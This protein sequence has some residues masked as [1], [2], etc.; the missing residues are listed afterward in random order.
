MSEKEIKAFIKKAVQ[1]YALKKYL[2]VGEAASYLGV[3]TTTFWDWRK[4]GLIKTTFIDGIQLF[5]REDLDKFVEE[6][7]RKI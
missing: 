6:Q 7:G 5:D 4:R 2:K 3:G 1:E